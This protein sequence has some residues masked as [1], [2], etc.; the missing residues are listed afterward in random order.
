MTNLKKKILIIEDEKLLA[1]MY[2][3][4][5]K[6]AGFKIYLAFNSEEGLFLVKKEKPDLIIL[7][8]L[9]PGENGIN[10]LEKLKKD[11]ETALI[12]VVVCSN[13]DDPEIKNKAKE[14]GVKT[15]LIKANYTPREIINEIKAY[16]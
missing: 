10:F 16:L 1:E 12:P 9:L 13:Y 2:R 14:L 3:D 5:F 11:P 7:D 15:Y 8:I 6:R 4:K